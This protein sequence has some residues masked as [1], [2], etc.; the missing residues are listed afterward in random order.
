[1]LSHDGPKAAVADVNG[2]G[3]DDIYIG[4]T[5]AKQGQLYLQNT[6]GGFIKKEASV[7]K[8]FTGF[9]DGAVLFFDC[10]KDGDNDLLL[11]SGGNAAMPFS[12]ELQHRLYINDGK[13]NF[14]IA[15]DAFP[16]NKDNIS[17]A[18]AND[19]D[20]DGDL[21]L[22]VG[23][24]CVSGEYGLTP[25]SHIY[26]NDGKGNFKDM[27]AESCK[28]ITDAGMVTGAVW[29]N[30]DGDAANELIITG[31]W[32]ATLIFK[33]S[34]NNFTAI[35]TNLD[36]K[37]GWWQTVA[38]ADLNND[39]KQ[40][41]I[42][43]NLGEN[44]YLHPDNKN[45]VKLY[46]S[47]F[48]NNGQTDKIITRTIDGKDKP[49][50]MKVELESQMPMLKKQNLRNNDYAKKSVQELFN[51]EIM[52]K[53]LVKQVNYSSSCIAYNNGNG[54]FVLQNLPVSI[55]LSSVKNVLPVDINDDGKI[56]LV[57]GGN[58][59]GFQPQL[60]RLDA[61]KGDILINDGSNNFSVLS[62]MQSGIAV[63]GQIRDLVLLKRNNKISILFLQNNEF[64]VLYEVI[65]K[66][67]LAIK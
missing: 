13:G 31:E 58:E 64:P 1:M 53:S 18:I 28:G 14:K 34:N 6:S 10:D 26:I 9:V 65:K 49:V 7:F 3:L 60:G 4:G 55:Q 16:A 56:D 12:R 61:S 59:F 21:D 52:E 62:Q 32:M 2:D 25:Q 50:F 17:V 40:D 44:F 54:N 66:K 22:F 46:L 29:A 33:Y 20:N 30:V 45:P 11:C 5:I 42:L 57:V 39:G 27:P 23:A 36:D 48:D 63:Q 67:T 35:K 24:R 51:A 8:Q 38:V 19:F 43:G 15:T 47:D 37:M 41:L